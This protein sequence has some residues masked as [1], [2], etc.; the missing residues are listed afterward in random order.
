MFKTILGGLYHIM[1]LIGRF[2]HSAAQ[3]SGA[4]FLGISWANDNRRG[5]SGGRGGLRVH[6]FQIS[7]FW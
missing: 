4:F 6:F 7:F 5:K 2:V 3:A 1:L